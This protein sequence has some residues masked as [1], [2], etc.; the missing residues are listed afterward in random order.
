MSLAELYSE[1]NVL[2]SVAMSFA[3]KLLDE[4]Y[5]IY[6]H[7]VDSVQTPD[8]MYAAFSTNQ[9]TYLLNPTFN[10]R[11]ATSKGLVTLT[12]GET[13]L[14]RFPTRATTTGAVSTADRV[15][16]PT[17][18]IEIGAEIPLDPYEHGSYLRWR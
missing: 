10:D 18:G 17:F 14:P 5:L 11:V 13:A 12:E 8:G 2:N 7:N 3:E 4:E 6:W 16:V 15:Q 1:R 9:A